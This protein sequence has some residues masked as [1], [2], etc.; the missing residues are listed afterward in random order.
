MNASC[1]WVDYNGRCWSCLE[2]ADYWASFGYDYYAYCDNGKQMIYPEQE[3]KVQ[4]VS[5]IA[6]PISIHFNDILVLATQYWWLLV[7]FLVGAIT[8][9]IV[10]FRVLSNNKWFSE[11]LKIWG[12]KK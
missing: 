1:Y 6:E 10:G 4:A 9:G 3:Q 5:H 7:I 11:L 2:L 12:W 8:L